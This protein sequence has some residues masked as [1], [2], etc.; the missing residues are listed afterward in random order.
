MKVYNCFQ[1]FNE[2]DIAEIRIQENWDTTDYFVIAESNYTHSGIEKPY[3]LLDNWKRFE[4][5]ESKIRRIQVDESLEEQRKYFPNETDEWVREK[6]QRFALQK[7]LDDMQPDDLIIIS[8][9]DEVPRSE[10]IAMIKEDPNDYDRYILNVPHFH[11]RLNYMRVRPVSVFPNV[12]VCRGRAFTNPMR[13]REYVFP[14]FTPPAD[15]VFVDHGGW[16]WTDF[17]TEDHVINKMKSFCHLDQNNKD[18]IESLKKL[19]WLIENKYDR[20]LSFEKKFEYVIID[21]YF[22]KCIRE[23]FDK[24]QHMIIPGA[25]HKVTELYKKESE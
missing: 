3:Y 14:W 20:D 22:P 6:Y 21:D 10:M 17:G 18:I 19:D 11:F 13:E 25:L 2:L 4:P 15:T 8:D 24:Y 12:L 5:Y 16:Q 7:G 23:N 9:C 1:I